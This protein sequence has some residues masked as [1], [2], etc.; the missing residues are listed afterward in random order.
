MTLY[1][2]P[3]GTQAERLTMGEIPTLCHVWVDH[4]ILGVITIA[5]TALAEVPPLESAL[6][7]ESAG[8]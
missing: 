7:G 5:E 3:D 8:S 2:L 4:P 1:V 6:R